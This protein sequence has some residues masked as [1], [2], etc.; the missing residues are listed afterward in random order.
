MFSPVDAF[1]PSQ[2]LSLRH[3]LGLEILALRQQVVVLKRK[4]GPKVATEV[5]PSRRGLKLVLNSEPWSEPQN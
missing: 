3:D 1:L 2:F 5:S 4:T